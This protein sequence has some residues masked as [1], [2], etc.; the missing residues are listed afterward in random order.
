MHIYIYIYIYT[1]LVLTNCLVL[2]YYYN[3]VSIV[4][5]H[6]CLNLDWM[7]CG[8]EDRS[9]QN[10][11]PHNQIAEIQYSSASVKF[12]NKRISFSDCYS[13]ASA[14][15]CELQFPD[16]VGHWSVL[17]WHRMKSMPVGQHYRQVAV[18]TLRICQAG[19]VISSVKK[20]LSW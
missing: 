4:C 6:T 9:R 14:G 10:N 13:V 18:T 20:C 5:L 2:Y 12:P 1:K 17:V 19:T 16:S 3:Y 15:L 11:I 8:T 7:Y